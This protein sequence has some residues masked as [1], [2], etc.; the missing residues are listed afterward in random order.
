MEFARKGSRVFTK[1]RCLLPWY[2]PRKHI[3]SW[4]I[5]SWTQNPQKAENICPRIYFHSIWSILLGAH[6]SVGAEA[7]RAPVAKLATTKAEG[8]NLCHQS[9]SFPCQ[10][11]PCLFSGSGCCCCEA[12]RARNAWIEWE[13]LL[14]SIPNPIRPLHTGPFFSLNS[15]VLHFLWAG[16]AKPLQRLPRGQFSVNPQVSL[17][18]PAQD[19]L[20]FLSPADHLRRSLAEWQ[21]GRAAR[22]GHQCHLLHPCGCCHQGRSGTFQYSCGDLHPCQW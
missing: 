17:P 8:H 10:I 7:Y 19:F 12:E 4:N 22:G 15:R 1:L 18:S 13:V 3:K 9:L 11:L 14:S 16:K 21:R 6:R 20:P 2:Q 5:I